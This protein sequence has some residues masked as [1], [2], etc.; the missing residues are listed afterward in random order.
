MSFVKKSIT[1][2]MLNRHTDE[3]LGL[4]CAADLLAMGLFPNG[5]EVS[6]SMAAY[7]AVRRH[8]SELP[9]FSLDDPSV[10]VV[11]VGDGHQ[12]RT[13]ALFA[14]RSAWM[15]Y[16][17]DPV[18]RHENS[19]EST[20]IKRIVVRRLSVHPIKIEDC[21]FDF[22]GKK[23]IV[24]SVH[25]HASN[26]SVLRGVKFDTLH[27]VSIPC[28]VHQ[29]PVSTKFLQFTDEAIWSPKNEITISFGATPDHHGW[30]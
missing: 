21:T 6:E 11:C 28:C 22:R 20:T 24:V 15:V 18:L 27:S 1:Y 9:G 19:G 17:V 23:L 29:P 14:M 26:Q 13:G 10:N 16:S 8:I 30:R 5:K 2:N 25:S 12:P 7:H 4:R 3:F